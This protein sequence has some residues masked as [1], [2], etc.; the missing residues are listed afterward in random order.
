MRKIKYPLIVSDFDG[1]LVNDDGTIAE[2]NKE[3][4]N[5]YVEAG[6]IFAI[7]TGRMPAGILARARELGLKGIVCCC[8]GA[9]IMDIESGEMLMEGRISP[10]TTY[11]IC[12]KMEE[13]HLHIHVYDAW[14][15]Y[16][17]M[18][19]EALKLYEKAVRTKGTLVLDKPI[20]EFVKENNLGAYKVLAMVEPQDNARILAALSAENFDGCDTTKSAAFLVEVINNRYS[21][22]TAVEYL[23]NRYGVDLKKVIAIGDQ[24]NDQPMIERVGL[25]IAVQNADEGLKQVADCVFEYTNEEGAV[26]KII[27]KYAYEE[28]E[29]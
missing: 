13:L 3:A 22:G 16:C 5:A 9:N 10:E 19:D 1:T 2:N 29:R 20:S 12:K 28:N 26:G 8:Q 14:E 24:T 17:N 18:D 11:A 15:F 23:A 7:S 25:G 6:G 4:I 27:E 21:K